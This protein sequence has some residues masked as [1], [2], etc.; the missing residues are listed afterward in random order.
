VQVRV[1]T[2]HLLLADHHPGR[3]SSQDDDGAGGEVMVYVEEPLRYIAPSR[4]AAAG[5]GSSDGGGGGGMQAQPHQAAS[6]GWVGRAANRLGLTGKKL[7][8]GEA[9]DAAAEELLV[10][11]HAGPDARDGVV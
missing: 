10:Q 2:Q 9:A 7:K 11:Q 8:G 1:E 3:G 5:N 4:A 6:L